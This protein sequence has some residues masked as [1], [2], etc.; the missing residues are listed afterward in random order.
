MKLLMPKLG[1]IVP[2]GWRPRIDPK[3]LQFRL[4]VSM[5]GLIVMGLTCVAAWTSWQMQQILISSHK[6]NIKMISD[7]VADDVMLYRQMEEM[8]TPEQTV[9]K[10]VDNRA[11][12]NLL[13]WVSRPQGTFI[14]AS[15]NGLIPTWQRLENP[16]VMSSAFQASVTPEVHRFEGRDFVACR[17]PLVIGNKTYGELYVAQDIT[18]DQEMLEES[19]ESLTLASLVAILLITAALT[20]FVRH[21]LS[22]LRQMGMITKAISAD[23]LGETRVLINQ[24]PSE[25]QEL[26]NTFNRMLGRISKAW[27]Q[28]QQSSE[29]QR[30][31]VSNVSHELRTPLTIVLGYLQ[32]IQR[33][34]HNLTEMQRE[35]LDISLSETGLTI[36]LLQDLLCLA[37]AD[38]GYL[39]YHLENLILNDVAAEVVKMADRFNDREICLEAETEIISV[40]ADP[41]RLQQV[42]VNLV[43][44]AVKYS[45][46]LTPVVVKLQQTETEAII[47]VCDRGPGIPLKHQARIFERFYRLDESR[48]RAIGGSGLGL[49]LVRTF[50]EGMGGNVSVVS[51]AGEGSTF[52]VTLPATTKAL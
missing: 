7:R 20:L 46:P 8:F 19:V 47:H 23:D 6:H 26:A 45:D 30:Q 13:L 15:T 38:D 27:T 44:N 28:Q 33:R 41:D 43:E 16:Q 34:G 25:I 12:R 24:A 29:Q 49:S 10:A 5:A 1:W 14:T 35:A 40:Y 4:T 9:Q 2:Q 52:T 11:G 31:F 3:S 37:R 18:A 21:S 51:C 36:R 32:S 50:T 39:P 42:L 17:G 48:N 22:P